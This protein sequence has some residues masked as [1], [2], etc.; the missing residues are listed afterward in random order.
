MRN[1]NK[2]THCTVPTLPSQRV[3]YLG[4]VQQLKVIVATEIS[5][6]FVHCVVVD[7]FTGCCIAELITVYLA[8]AYEWTCIRKTVV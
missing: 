1:E 6:P 4:D 2:T 5:V 7:L 3:C 8:V